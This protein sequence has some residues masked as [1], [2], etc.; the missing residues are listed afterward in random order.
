MITLKIS[1]TTELR[2]ETYANTRLKK[3][4]LTLAVDLINPRKDSDQVTPLAAHSV[5]LSATDANY[6]IYSLQDT[7]E[8]LVTE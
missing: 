2:I 8:E 6:L 3:V 1:D 4:G 7:L 5:W